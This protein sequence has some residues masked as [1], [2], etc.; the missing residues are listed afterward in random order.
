M[1]TLLLIDKQF[2]LSHQVHSAWYLTKVKEIENTIA[3]DGDVKISFAD[4]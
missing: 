1:K 3:E 2:M 4:F